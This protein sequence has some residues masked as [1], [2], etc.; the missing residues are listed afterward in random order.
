M[1]SLICILLFASSPTTTV[2]DQ[3]FEIPAN[4]WKYVD[5]TLEKPA[6]LHAEYTVESGPDKARLQLLRSSDLALRAKVQQDALDETEPGK[7]GGI[8][9]QLRSTGEYV[10]VV[11]N[12]LGDEPA[13]VHLKIWLRKWPETEMIQLSPRRQFFVILLSFGTFFGIVTWSA[14]RLLRGIRQ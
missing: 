7:S 2:V 12:N 3:V 10:V 1:V 9:P 6:I 11:D 5:V 14:R 13:K 4:K 8:A